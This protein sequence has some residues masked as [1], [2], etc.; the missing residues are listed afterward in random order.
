MYRQHAPLMLIVGLALW[1]GV[2]AGL[3]R[4]GWRLPTLHDT[5]PLAHGA[6]MVGG[7]LGTLISLERAVAL[8]TFLRGSHWSALPYLA[9]LLTA[10]GAI[11]LLVNLSLA[12]VLIS[13]GS[14]GLVLMFAYIVARHRAAYTLTMAL[15]AG[16]WLA[17]NLLW[18]AGKP[19]YHSAPWWM[20][21]LVLTIAGER[22]EL[23]RVMR[24]TR[25]NIVAFVGLVGLLVLGLVVCLYDYTIGM[26]LL[27]VASIGLAGW[28]LRYDVIHRTLRLTGLSRYMAVC[29][30][31]GYGWLGISGGLAL[32]YGGVKAGL[33]YDAILH[34][35]FLGFVFSMIFAHA[36]II[37]PSIVGLQIGYTPLFYGHLALLHGSVLLRVAGDIGA[38]HAA[39][40]WGAMLNALVLLAFLA[41]TART[42]QTAEAKPLLPRTRSAY[43]TYAL[44]V[45]MLVVGSV[46]VGIGLVKGLQPPDPSP[47][48]RAALARELGYPLDG[49]ERGERLYQSSCAA[50]H[51]LNL[52][53][54]KG[55]GKDLLTGEFVRTQSDTALHQM[56]VQ[57]R[58]IW[59]AR[60]T[61][62][63][64]M[65][66]RGGNPTLSDA[67]IDA[68][69]AYI[70]T[71]A[72]R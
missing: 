28:L 24:L 68:I 31:L 20:A 13:A 32:A 58:P 41:N 52:R 51:G 3:V 34:A 43:A 29:L 11:S 60:N 67:D 71:E 27:G 15:G 9:P 61:T 5:M 7:M 57:G 37:L 72:A 59:D 55:L 25:A 63:V 53:G 33:A 49:V 42:L 44:V 30:A 6:L 64:D 70:R 39:R 66:P 50:C 45:P 1:G 35:V 22:L 8:R 18:L 12:A 48:D 17:G 4:S 10:L 54:V 16:S 46:L 26:R 19:L 62:G 36:P 14:L 23:S 69:I 21:F 40:R 56:I 38:W 47:V 2:W 65:P